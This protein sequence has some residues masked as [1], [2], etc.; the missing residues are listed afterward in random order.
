MVGW[1]N[2]WPFK[3]KE[4]QAKEEREFENRVFPLGEAQREMA[5]GI[6]RQVT[7]KKLRDNEKLFAFISAKDRYVQAEEDPDA[8]ELSRAQLIKMNWL[9]EDDLAPILALVVLDARVQ[10]LSD[11]PTLEAVLERAEALRAPAE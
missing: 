3:S 6:L 10:S 7:S 5:L 9:K 11:Y 8:L 2:G 4:Q 1:F